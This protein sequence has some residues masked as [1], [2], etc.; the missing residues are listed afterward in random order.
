[1]NRHTKKQIQ[2]AVSPLLG[3]REPQIVLQSSLILCAVDGVWV[4]DIGGLPTPDSVGVEILLAKK[5]VLDRLQAKRAK[6]KSANRR[7]YLRRKLKALTYDSVNG[8]NME[9]NEETEH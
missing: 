2:D 3:H 1:M 6:R 5:A 9:N 7:N 8:N 4:S